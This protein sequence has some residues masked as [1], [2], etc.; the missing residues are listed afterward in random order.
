MAV[1]N[2][3][4]IRRRDQSQVLRR[5]NAGVKIREVTEGEKK[6][7]VLTMVAST[8][9]AVDWGGYREILVHK[10][11]A[12]SR[13]A[14]KAM[15]V[16]HDPNRI[17]GPIT[18]IRVVG[19][20]MEIDAELLPDARMDSGIT[21]AD[22]IESGALRGVSI[23]YHFSEKDTQY[24]RDTRTLTVNAWRLLEVSLTPIPAD[25]SA[26]LRSRSLPDH[27]NKSG[28]Q[29]QGTR[30]NFM[31]WLKARGFIFEKLNDEQVDHLRALHK[32]GKEPEAEFAK[33]ARESKE[34]ASEA[35][36]AADIKRNRE[37][38]VRAESQGLTPSKYLGMTDADA[39]EAMLR[40]LAEKNRTTTKTTSVAT[41]VAGE[42]EADKQRDAIAAAM[43]HR[44]GQGVK[45]DGNPYAGRSLTDMARKYARQI[46]I[47]GSEDWSKTDLAYFILGRTANVTGFRDAGNISM[48]SFPSFVMLNAIT[49]TVTKGFE[50]APKG[51]TGPSGQAIYSTRTAPDFK[52][53]YLGGLGT[54]N[55]QEVAENAAAPELD[56]TEG[57]Y[58]DTLKAWGGTLSVS[59]QALVSDDTASF[60]ASLRK[61]G[62]IA[63]KS[64]ERRLIQKFLRGVAT[65]DASTW[66]S[67]TTSGSTPVYTTADTAAAARANISKGNAAMQIKVGLDGN[68][69]GNST[70]FLLAPPT[71]G[72]YLAGILG[73][74]PG[75][76]VSNGIG[77][78][79]ELVTSAFLESSL[80]TG[81]STT[82][83][84]H[85]ADPNLVDALILTELAGLNGPQVMEYDPGSAFVRNWKILD[86]FE[87]DLFW[88]ANKAGTN[89]IFGAQQATT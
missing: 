77:A 39:N 67:N 80:I 34:A 12:I 27:L 45:V 10:D 88:A 5:F 4:G 51:L 54:A 89:V 85:I 69:T 35:Q 23:G 6:R 32:D 87:A 61:V 7:K 13:D 15:L 62:F 40:D 55:L 24:D 73:Q 70:R 53:F 64:R 56:K 30:M 25:D 21:V 28:Q 63:Q 78:N 58:N 31:Q 65:T 81:N 22:A 52:S 38:A 42:D 59:F 20:E 49:K 16:N 47:R 48:A 76:V 1:M 75:Q 33:D 26:G 19:E 18:A 66:T 44:A 3:S 29:P 2:V 11:S 68:P 86:V 50:M 9:R 71:A 79:Y 37:I 82:S 60:D 57:A 14:A 72:I 84:Y 46:G 43:Q 83:Y 74:A 8:S 17:A 36:R 41:I